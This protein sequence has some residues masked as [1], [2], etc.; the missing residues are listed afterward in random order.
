MFIPKINRNR[1]GHN[2]KYNHQQKVVIP[3]RKEKQSSNSC[4]KY[5]VRADKKSFNSFSGL[6][7][8]CFYFKVSSNMNLLVLKT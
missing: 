1:C 8:S 2:A 4:N 3:D 6:E 5:L 7:N